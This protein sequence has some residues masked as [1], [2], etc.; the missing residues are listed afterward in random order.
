M[1]VRFGRAFVGGAGVVTGFTTV[2]WVR[3]WRAKLS[4]TP[5]GPGP[6]SG[7]E[8]AE[9]N[10]VIDVAVAFRTSPS[11]L[12]VGTVAIEDSGSFGFFLSEVN[13]VFAEEIRLDLF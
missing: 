6:T 10:E 13:Q 1:I 9:W 11:V 8:R 4:V 2:T 3:S 7:P 12:W 5:D